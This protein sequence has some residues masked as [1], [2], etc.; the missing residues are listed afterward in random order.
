M[1]ELS[2]ALPALPPSWNT[3]LYLFDGLK[4]LSALLWAQLIYLCSL[5]SLDAVNSC[6]SYDYCRVYYLDCA[7]K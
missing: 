5:V 3:W 6:V 4:V 1:C 2:P 7:A